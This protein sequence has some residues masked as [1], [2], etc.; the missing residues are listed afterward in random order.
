MNVNFDIH[1]IDKVEVNPNDV[2][3]IKF[4]FG[5]YSGDMIDFIFKAFKQC[6]PENKCMLI[7]DGCHIQICSQKDVSFEPATSEELCSFLNINNAERI[8]V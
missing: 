3:V 5:E 6:F 7:P 4:P 2:F 1:K 8:G